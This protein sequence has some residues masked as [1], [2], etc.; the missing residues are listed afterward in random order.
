[1]ALPCNDMRDGFVV[2]RE[3]TLRVG[4]FAATRDAVVVVVRDTTLRDAPDAD[5]RAVVVVFL[6]DV[7]IVGR[8][9]VA[10]RDDAV[11]VP[12][13]T[14]GVVVA[15]DTTLRLA[16]VPRGDVTVVVA[17]PRET[18]F[19]E[20]PRDVAG[21]DVRDVLPA[22]VA[23]GVITLFWATGA[24]GSANTER[25]DK[26]VEQTKN[27]PAS[28]NTVPIAFLNESAKLRFFIKH[29]LCSGKDRNPANFARNGHAITS[30][31]YIIISF[32]RMS[33]NKKTRNK[34]Y[35]FMN[36]YQFYFGKIHDIMSGDEE[37]C[38]ICFSGVIHDRRHRT[39]GFRQ[40]HVCPKCTKCNRVVRC[41]GHR[42][43]NTVQTG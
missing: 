32:L 34:Q 30:L 22:R 33:V 17:F 26:N 9:D 38:I 11:A 35:E 37:I 4:L 8:P 25:I 36:L 18:I 41:P 39:G 42:A 3:R 21:R 6:R 27:A 12:A 10:T 7:V 2:V 24:I 28:K 20:F 16:V 43:R 13:A 15:R 14:V 1:M 5:G 19:A 23:W 31:F 40:S 29:S